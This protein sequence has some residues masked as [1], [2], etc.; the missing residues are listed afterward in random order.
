MPLR[1]CIHLDPCW[2]P[3]C[4]LKIQ[5]R[6]LA[7]LK[8]TILAISLRKCYSNDHVSVIILEAHRVEAPS[9]FGTTTTKI[10]IPA[11]LWHGPTESYIHMLLVPRYDVRRWR[12]CGVSCDD[13]SIWHVT[14]SSTWLLTYDPV[15]WDVSCGVYYPI[16]EGRSEPGGEGGG[17]T[18]VV[19]DV[20]RSVYH[21]L[22]EGRS[23]ACTV[24]RSGIITSY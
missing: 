14:S 8:Q 15:M 13:V 10:S 19:W 9:V 6:C 4:G 11:F 17:A 12:C 18:P 7:L 20:S 24:I 23:D 21:L 5:C 2:W 22:H 16:H 3:W 1:Q